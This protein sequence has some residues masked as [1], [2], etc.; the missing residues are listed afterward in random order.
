MEH[1]I[2]VVMTLLLQCAST[3]CDLAVSLVWHQNAAASFSLSL[4]CSEIRDQI[5]AAF[6]LKMKHADLLPNICMFL[7]SI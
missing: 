5:L 4:S 1:A 7:V 2:D 6:I 3:D